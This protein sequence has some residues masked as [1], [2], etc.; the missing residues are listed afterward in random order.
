M[1]L[2]RETVAI[3]GV[4]W[5]VGV[6]EFQGDFVRRGGGWLMIDSRPEGRGFLWDV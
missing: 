1:A 5:C 3:I 6:D 4:I 2:A